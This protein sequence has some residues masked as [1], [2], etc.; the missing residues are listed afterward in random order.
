MDH[1]VIAIIPARG[2]SKGIFRKNVRLLAGKPLVVHSIISAKNAQ[3]VSRVVVSTDDREIE[4]MSLSNG[5]EVV[6]RPRE[7]STDD[8]SSEAALIHVLDTLEQRDG[9]VPELVVF[10]QP[11]SPFRLAEDIDGTVDALLVGKADSAFSSCIEHFTGRWRESENGTMA[12]LNFKPCDRPRRQEYPMEYLENG[13]VYVFY[14]WVLKNFGSRLGGR[15]VT[16]IMPPLRSMQ[17]D[18]SGDLEMLEFLIRNQKNCILPEIGPVSLLVLDFDGVLTD[19]CVLVDQQGHESV[20]CSREDSFGIAK[21]Q[22]SG[23]EVLVISK[24]RNPVVGE[25]CRKLGIEC[26]HGCDNKLL[27]LQKAALA[28]GIL[29]VNI[30]YVGNDENDIECLNWVGFPVAVADAVPEVASLGCYHTSKPG[31]KGAVREVADL[32]LGKEKHS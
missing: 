9:Y 3:S 5:A 28:K 7:I 23:F 19:N 12:P 18:C 15:I 13:S 10:L 32:L 24:E 17:I 4:T 22:E 25:R 30:A 31:G 2:G 16:Y 6:K 8:A 14:P 26:I 21:L 1:E 20:L 29:P 11:T 27:A